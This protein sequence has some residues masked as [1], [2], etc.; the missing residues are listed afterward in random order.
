MNQFHTTGTPA[1]YRRTT[2]G[3]F[4]A[5]STALTGM[6]G[7]M[8]AIAMDTQHRRLLLL[9]N[10]YTTLDAIARV[11]QFEAQPELLAQDLEASGLIEQAE[12]RGSREWAYAASGPP[13]QVRHGTAPGIMPGTVP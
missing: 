8:G 2:K 13:W 1:V 10:G 5:S 7:E 6:I 3:Q 12:Y 9:V 11:G 4:A